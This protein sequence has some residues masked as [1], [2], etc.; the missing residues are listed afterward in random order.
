[1][2]KRWDG[3]GDLRGAR[4]GRGNGC[5]CDR[6][7]RGG[8]GRARGA[9]DFSMILPRACRVKEAGCRCEG[10]EGW[11]GGA[12]AA[13]RGA[14]RRGGGDLLRGDGAGLRDEGELRRGDASAAGRECSR[15]RLANAACGVGE[16][17]VGVHADQ[18]RTPSVLRRRARTSSSRR[19]HT[20]VDRSRVSPGHTPADTCHTP[21]HVSARERS[22][23]FSRANGRFS[24]ARASGA[25]RAVRSP[26]VPHA[27]QH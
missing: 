8:R 13:A 11:S 1:M 20:I 15:R 27:R 9:R 23:P 3:R 21:A 22:Q 10:A 6:V 12:D 5:R 7:R 18:R 4:Q 24:R 2:E 25:V 26:T 14:E 17:R 16:A 19:S